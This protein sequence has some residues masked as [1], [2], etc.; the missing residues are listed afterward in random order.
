MTESYRILAPK[1]LT[2]LL[3]LAHASRLACRDRGHVDGAG[4]HAPRDGLRRLRRLHGDKMMQVML[5]LSRVRR[6][7]VGYPELLAVLAAAVLGLTLKPPLEW[8]ASH[9]G[10]NILLAV[11]AFA[12]AVTIHRAQ[13]AAPSHFDMAALADRS[14]RRRYRSPGAVMG[15]LPDSRGR[16]AS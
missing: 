12:T 8:A 10:I 6:L 16:A 7:L 13:D 2:A 1:K 3:E 15:S 5:L 4:S 9:Q 14:G 11:L